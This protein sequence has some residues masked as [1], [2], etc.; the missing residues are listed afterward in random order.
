MHRFWEIGIVSFTEFIAQASY[1]IFCLAF[2]MHLIAYDTKDN[3]RRYANTCSQQC[4]LSRRFIHSRM[5]LFIKNRICFHFNKNKSESEQLIFFRCSPFVHVANNYSPMLTSLP[6]D[7]DGRIMN[8]GMVENCNLCITLCSAN[9]QWLL[10]VGCWANKSLC[11]AIICICILCYSI[12]W[13][14][15]SS[16]LGSGVVD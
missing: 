9:S 14:V 11:R 3:G 5:Y 2:F 16:R 1:S 8:E 7:L 10:V 4:S 15:S 6:I 13:G 12:F